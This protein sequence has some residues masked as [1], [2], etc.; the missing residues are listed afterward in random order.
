M[1]HARIT[2][3]RVVNNME[4]WRQQLVRRRRRTVSPR[5]VVWDLLRHAAHGLLAPRPR[6][7][8]MRPNIIYR[9]S[10]R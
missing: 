10:G 4:V 3:R 6:F 2:S 8:Y 9:T 1:H 7:N 5:N